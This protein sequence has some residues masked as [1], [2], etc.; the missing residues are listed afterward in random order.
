MPLATSPAAEGAVRELRAL[1]EGKGTSRLGEKAY[2]AI[3][4][5]WESG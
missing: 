5:A 2:V 4:S 1:V 3:N